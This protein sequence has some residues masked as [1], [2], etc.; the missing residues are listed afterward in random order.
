MP[1]PTSQ[2]TRYDVYGFD[3]HGNDTTRATPDTTG[4][5]VR[6]SDAAA[7]EAMLPKEGKVDRTKDTPKTWGATVEYQ[8]SIPMCVVEFDGPHGGVIYD[9]HDLPAFHLEAMAREQEHTAYYK[10]LEEENRR[11]R[12]ALKGIAE[13]GARYTGLGFTCAKKAAAALS[14]G[15]PEPRDRLEETTDA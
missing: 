4:D 14:G 10:G 7:I 5:W 11:L 12:E 15:N 13:F 8:P 6:Y 1:D 2:L 3:D 9:L